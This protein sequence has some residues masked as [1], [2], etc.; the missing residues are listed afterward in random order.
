MVETCAQP[1]AKMPSRDVPSDEIL[2][3]HGLF[4]IKILKYVKEE[5]KNKELRAQHSWA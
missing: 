2:G 5:P 1:I 3:F 4:K